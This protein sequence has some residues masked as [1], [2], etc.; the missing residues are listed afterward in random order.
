MPLVTRPRRTQ[1]TTR[2]RRTAALLVVL[3]GLILLSG[4]SGDRDAGGATS[5]AVAPD[6]GQPADRDASTGDE[7]G[8][9]E[10]AQDIPSGG[11]DAPENGPPGGATL[12]EQIVRTGDIAVEVDD[13]T[14]AANRITSVVSAAGGN[15]GSDQR[16]GDADDGSAD[17][18]LRIPPDSFDDVLETI[19]DLG[20]ELSRSVAAEDVSTVVADVDARVESLQNS[21]DRLLALAAQAASV[22]DLIT[23]ESELSFRQ[24]ELESLLAQQRAL[25]DQVSLATLSVRLT[26]SSQPDTAD[27]GFLAGLADGWNALLDFGAGLISVIGRVLPWLAVLAVISVPLWFLWRHR[28]QRSLPSS[29]ADPAAVPALATFGPAPAAADSTAEPVSAR[30]ASEPARPPE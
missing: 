8:A 7:S 21:V 27:T 10:G 5:G 11:G 6:V 25:Q 29:D 30:A 20:E 18:V 3:L 4:C 28:R 17:L 22:S 26:A 13:I 19:S 9:G 12:T 2:L 24:S 23:I 16:Y 14:S 1:T 15:V